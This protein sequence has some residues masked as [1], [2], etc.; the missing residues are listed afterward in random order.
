[1]RYFNKF[2]FMHN[3]TILYP[4][5]VLVFK[6]QCQKTIASIVLIWHVAVNLVHTS[7]CFCAIVHCCFQPKL[8]QPSSQTSATPLFSSLGSAGSEAG[9]LSTPKLPTA[10]V[11]TRPSVPPTSSGVRMH[12]VETVYFIASETLSCLM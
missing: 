11:F 6:Q 3:N 1:M 8:S 12:E 2:I 9:L 10:P 5:K 7:V 4:V